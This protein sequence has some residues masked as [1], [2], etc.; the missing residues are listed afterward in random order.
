MIVLVAPALIGH[1]PAYIRIIQEYVAPEKCR[2]EVV[3]N[4]RS[5]IKFI[6]SLYKNS[7]DQI[8]FLHGEKHCFFAALCSLIFNTIRVKLILYYALNEHSPRKRVLG[9]FVLGLC[10]IFGVELL[11]IDYSERNKKL[12]SRLSVTTLYDPVLISSENNTASA[13]QEKRSRINFLVAGYIDERK[14]VREI[15]EALLSVENNIESS[16][17]LNVRGNFSPSIDMKQLES[18]VENSSIK[19]SLVN[20]GLTDQEL[21]SA[22]SENDVICTI[23]SRHLGSSGMVINAVEFGKPVLFVT[24]GVLGEYANDLGITDLPDD[25]L[26]ESIAK[27]LIVL[28][29]N[30]H[31]SQWSQYSAIDQSEFLT[32]RTPSQFAKTLLS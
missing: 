7:E 8:V 29:G 31:D 23:Y 1:F 5:R 28:A 4:F 17:A 2:V 12:G 3:N 30:L 21:A 32:K 27:S 26:P 20:A 15:I 18:L 9:T 11:S 24:T 14:C 16:I 19:V 13:V 10:R 6:Y 22:I 25:C